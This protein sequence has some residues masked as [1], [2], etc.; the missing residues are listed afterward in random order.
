MTGVERMPND[1]TDVPK[2][3]GSKKAF[4]M[5]HTLVSGKLAGKKI[6]PARAAYLADAIPALHHMRNIFQYTDIFK[7]VAVHRHQ[8]GK[9]PRCDTAECIF[10]AQ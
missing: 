9:A 3:A 2:R 8:I 1:M 4:F 10:L 5:H 6:T 7:R